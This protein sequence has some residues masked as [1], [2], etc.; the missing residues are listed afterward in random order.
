MMNGLQSLPQWREFFN[1]PSSSI[2]GS[3]NAV[4]PV[5][6]ILGLVTSAFVGD[7]FG[8][9]LPFYE[10]LSFLLL[11]AAIQ[12]A[13][14]NTAMFIVS[15]LLIGF[16]TGCVIQT[17]PILVSELSYPTHRGRFS[18][19][20]FSTY[21]S[22]LYLAHKSRLRF[23]TSS[24]SA[25]SWLR[26]SHTAHSESTARLPGESRPSSKERFRSCKPASH[27]QFQNHLGISLYLNSNRAIKLTGGFPDGSLRKGMPK[28]RD[29]SSSNITPVGT[30]PRLSSRLRWKKSKKALK[31]K[32]SYRKRLRL[33]C[34]TRLPTDAERPFPPLLA[35][36]AVGLAIP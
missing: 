21:V 1:N 14:Q 28:R 25:H 27:G 18:S 2:L 11:G 26:G 24:I 12:G 36:M 22:S 13:A 5:G 32:H 29:R 33:I 20:Y 23:N 30:P 15:R 34:F 4:Y 17:C 10:G 6:K 9:R 8:R 7:R 31:K 35:S 19:L 16:G 3:I